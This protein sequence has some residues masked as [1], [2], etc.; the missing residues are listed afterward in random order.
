M[1]G[2]ARWYKLPLV[3]AG[4]FGMGRQPI[5]RS[6]SGTVFTATKMLLYVLRLASPS[7]Y[8]RK[9]LKDET[10]VR[11]FTTIVF[12]K[13]ASGPSGGLLLYTLPVASTAPS[14]DSGSADGVLVIVPT[15]RG[16]DVAN[17]RLRSMRLRY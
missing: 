4:R 2:T 10:I 14:S 16:R 3:S 13:M 8:L 9:K 11:S 1:Y 5:G 12:W 6:E 17:G 15:G 7:L